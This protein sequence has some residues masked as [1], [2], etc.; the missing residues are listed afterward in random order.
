VNARD[1]E[2]ALSVASVTASPASP[3][4][5]LGVCHYEIDD[6]RFPGL[7]GLPV[8]GASISL[9]DDEGYAD[10]LRELPLG[11]DERKINVGNADWAVITTASGRPDEGVTA[12]LQ[13]ARGARSAQIEVPTVGMPEEEQEAVLLLL[14]D[15]VLDR[16]LGAHD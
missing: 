10:A 13:L 9:S 16:W 6:D 15:L 5:P 2:E 12:S 11:A 14:A 3:G 8:Y 7:P 4:E 1:I